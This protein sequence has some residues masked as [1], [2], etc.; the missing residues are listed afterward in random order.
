MLAIPAG[1]AVLTATAGP[2]A[3]DGVAGRW[4]SVSAFGADECAIRTDGALWC[5]GEA[6]D[7]SSPGLSWT[8]IAPRTRWAEV[9]NAWFHSCGIRTDRTLWCWGWNHTG[10]FGIGVTTG[11]GLPGEVFDPGTVI[12]AQEISRSRWL[13]VA[14]GRWFTCAIRV[15]GTLWCWGDNRFGQVGQGHVSDYQNGYGSPMRVG[16]ATDWKQVASAGDSACGVR[17]GG[18]LWCWGANN[19]GQ[20]GDGTTT[21]RLV[22]TQVGTDTGWLSVSTGRTSACALRTG[23]QLWCWGNNESGQI[24]DGTTTTRLVPTQVGKGVTWTTVDVGTSHACGLSGDR[25]W[26]WGADYRGPSGG[27]T[28]TPTRVDTDF[29]WTMVSANE[30]RTCGIT[31]GQLLRCWWPGGSI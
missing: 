7:A 29:A 16:T 18:T 13:D 30:E 8:E 19:H 20:I 9:E 3:A 4:R 22:P 14:P 31:T 1:L 21:T 15:D 12:P 2:A 5:W 11:A 23:G 26:C 10:A 27:P 25:L 17:T 28:M 6:F 24:G